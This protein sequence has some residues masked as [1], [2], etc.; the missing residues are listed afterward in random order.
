MDAGE[1]QPQGRCSTKKG[2]RDGSEGDGSERKKMKEMGSTPP[3]LTIFIAGP[4]NLSVAAPCSVQHAPT[5][6][7]REVSKKIKA[8][9]SRTDQA[10]RP[11]PEFRSSAK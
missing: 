1:R 2:E 9:F 7:F 6:L 8:D 4:P 11:K 5:A 3:R 10:P